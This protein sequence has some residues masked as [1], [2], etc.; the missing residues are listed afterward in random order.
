MSQLTNQIRQQQ[1]KQCG[2]SVVL[3]LGVGIVAMLWMAAVFSTLM[4]SF[5]K[6]TVAKNDSVSRATAEAAVDWACEQLSTS[7]G[8]AD[9]DGS[10]SGSYPDP[11]GV[12][13]TVPPDQ[14]PT[15]CTASVNLRNVAPT[16]ASAIY[17]PALATSNTNNKNF[18]RMLTV[19]AN[20]PGNVT[21]RIRVALMPVPASGAGNGNGNPNQNNPTEQPL[22]V[23]ALA[24]YGKVDIK[25][26]AKTYSVDSSDANGV[27]NGSTFDQKNA[28]ADVASNTQIAL[29][30]GSQIAG[31]VVVYG[32]T[33][34]GTANVTSDNAKGTHI[35]GVISTSGTSTIDSKN[36]QNVAND[37][38]GA[39]QTKVT[40]APIPMIST[41]AP[42]TAT[43]INLTSV[44][45]KVALTGGTSYT[46][47]SL[48]L[49]SKGQFDITG[50]G[51]VN[52]YVN[53]AGGTLTISSKN[54]SAA[55]PA[56]LRIWYKG[57][58]D[59]HVDNGANFAGIIYAP[60]AHVH[61]DNGGMIVGAVLAKNVTI[62]NGGTFVYDTD[63]NN[64]NLGLN[65]QWQT[66]TT[67]TTT[68]SAFSAASYQALSW[69]EF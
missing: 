61:V 41:T 23:N 58:E 48:N 34:T 10:N 69:Q 60:N 30:N 7:Q 19:T 57:N 49:G 20:V 66:P 8:Q 6:V 31:D 37:P 45:S 63:L 56:N 11:N 67:T 53:G 14:L 55:I 12:T 15:G 52:I 26:G 1:R 36:V 50:S 9:L 21:K 40:H 16:S 54:V 68:T 13:T 44:N 25:G 65:A 59:V 24:A 35:N 43:P 18:W 17:S 28:N 2:F 29:S 38:N 62:D 47:T 3:I 22:F 27:F 32:N 42:T 46:T 64:T 5:R 4:P 33:T 51:A 39:V